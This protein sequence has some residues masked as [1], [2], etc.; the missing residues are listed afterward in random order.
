MFELYRL[1]ED[2]LPSDH[3]KQINATYY[4][5]FLSEKIPSNAY[6]LDLGCG[7]GKSID[8]FR[9]IMPS[10]TWF[11][12]DIIGSPEVEKRKIMDGVFVSYD[13]T[14]IP[15][16]E[17]SF[18]FVY[19]CQALEHIRNPSAII[20]EVHRILKPNGFFAGS[21][22]HLEPYHSYSTWNYT[23]YG[24]KLLLE[25]GGLTPLEFRPGIDSLTLIMRRIFGRPKFFDRWWRNESPVNRAIEVM[26]RLKA[27]RT[28][29]KNAAKLLYCGQFCFLSQKI[30]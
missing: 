17:H 14:S 23:P 22:S 1:I 27:A 13:G 12:L 18:D 16:A 10:T 5:E 19:T 15:F 30:S 3:S 6:V 24:L 25:D 21:T 29:T 26:G 4:I 11:G 2:N 20:K 8:I 9:E 28:M 7:D